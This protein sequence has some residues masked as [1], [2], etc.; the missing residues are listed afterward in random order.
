MLGLM[1]DSGICPGSQS[2]HFR[3][4]RAISQHRSFQSH[5]GQLH[6]IRHLG[7]L[8]PD[9]HSPYRRF[10][11]VVVGCSMGTLA[12]SPVGRDTGEHVICQPFTYTPSTSRVFLGKFSTLG[13]GFVN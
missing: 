13:E 3:T 9:F 5:N 1:A 6:T 7:L 2:C 11:G 4:N 10:V 8:R 12:R